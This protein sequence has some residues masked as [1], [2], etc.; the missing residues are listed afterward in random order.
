MVA[1]GNQIAALYASDEGMADSLQAAA[2]AAG[3]AGGG[4]QSGVK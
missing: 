1:L 3:G 2:K 4:G